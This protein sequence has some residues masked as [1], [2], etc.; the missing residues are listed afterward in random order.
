M[1]AAE[2]NLLLKIAR[3]PE[4]QDIFDKLKKGKTVDSSYTE[5]VKA[6][7]DF[8]L[9]QMELPEPWSGHLS[10]AKL[11]FIGTNPA[12]A[13]LNKEQVPTAKW[14]DEDI[15][16]FFDNRWI[17]FSKPGALNPT[18]IGMIKFTD[19]LIENCQKLKGCNK[20]HDGGSYSSTDM[21]K[22][23]DLVVCV[24]CVHC[25][26]DNSVGVDDCLGIEVETW[27]PSILEKFTGNVI[28]LH[29]AKAKRY[30]DFVKE[31]IPREDVIVVQTSHLSPIS[32]ESDDERKKNLLKQL[33]R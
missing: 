21:N 10:K 18:W 16:D 3:N 20:I 7:I 6:Q 14:D 23:A 29:G 24:D 2:K 19:L 22:L 15:C 12:V 28:V 9:K 11:M 27:L 30:A 1:K 26:S 32:G 4:P 13:D 25:R 33:K 31:N 17:N 5:I 8:G